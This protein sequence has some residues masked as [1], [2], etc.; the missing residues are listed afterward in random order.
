MRPTLFNCDAFVAYLLPLLLIILHYTGN[1]A[2]LVLVLCISI[3]KIKK[4]EILFPAYWIASLSS[5]YFDLGEGLSAGRFMSIIII[6]SLIIRFYRHKQKVNVGLRVLFVIVLLY[7]LL[8]SL[9]GFAHSIALF[10]MMLLNLVPFFFIANNTDIDIR[11]MLKYM[12]HVSFLL[13][14]YSSYN[15]YI[16]GAFLFA[17]RYLEDSSEGINANNLSMLIAQ[18]GS[19]QIAYFMYSK[20]ITA[21]LLSLFGAIISVLLIFALGSRASLLA[22]IVAILF[23]V[24]YS[25]PKL[26]KKYIG[27]IILIVFVISCFFVNFFMSL[28]T[29]LLERYSIDSVESSGGGGRADNI[30]I[31]MGEIFPNYPI[32]GIGIG[33][34]PV[35]MKE[36]HLNNLAHNIIVDPLSQLGMFGFILFLLF[37]APYIAIVIKMI[38]QKNDLFFVMVLAPLIAAVVNGIGEIVFFEKFFWNDLGLC[39][40][41]GKMYLGIKTKV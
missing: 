31:I 28:D 30:K 3:L 5:M 35:L 36:Y 34:T 8:S 7:S 21:K 12:V 37:M 9:L 16:D 26:K 40:L 11:S 13:L 29:P 1:I 14:I 41:A 27:A 10:F 18:C 20:N 33:G 23:S 32:F 6:S 22:L 24:Y 25:I 38:K 17:N 39:C 4:V 2:F 15:A 19:L